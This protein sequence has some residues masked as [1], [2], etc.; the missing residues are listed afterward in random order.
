MVADFLA[1]RG[2]STFVAQKFGGNIKESM[3][4]RGLSYAEYSGPSAE[5][6]KDLLTP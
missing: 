2:V 6:V 1:D 5:A 3:E 4:R